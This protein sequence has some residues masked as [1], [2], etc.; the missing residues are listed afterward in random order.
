VTENYTVGDFEKEALAKLEELYAEKNFAILV[1]GSGL[2][3]DAI[4]K[5]FDDFPEIATAIR[6][7]VSNNYKKKWAN[8]L[9]RT[10]A[11]K[12]SSLL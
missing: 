2:Y 9:A 1:G 10:I 12:R 11:R 4:L 6:D 5:G 8:I 7:L 3:V